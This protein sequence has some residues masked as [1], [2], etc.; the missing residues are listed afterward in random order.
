[1]LILFL[2]SS[3]VIFFLHCMLNNLRYEKIFRETD[4]WIAPWHDS[5]SDVI[6]LGYH[7][8]SIL[9]FMEFFFFSRKLRFLRSPCLLLITELIS[10]D[11]S[12]RPTVEFF[13][14]I[15]SPS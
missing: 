10:L 3:T 8:E 11:T 1:M 9:P 13:F 14:K 7:G 12:G 5:S 15:T 6:F 4:K 2:L